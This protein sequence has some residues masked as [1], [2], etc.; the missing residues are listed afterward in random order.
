MQ[1]LQEKCEESVHDL[2][3]YMA[4][5]RL[6]AN[7]SKTHIIVVESGKKTMHQ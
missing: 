4:V 6:A 5:N 2:L 7:D 3:T 1:T